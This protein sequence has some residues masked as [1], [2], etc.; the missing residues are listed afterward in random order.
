MVDKE[1]LKGQIERQ[2]PMSPEEL[3]R[4]FNEDEVELIYR[5]LT[6]SAEDRNPQRQVSDEHRC[7][8]F[9][10]DRCVVDGFNCSA[11]PTS[12]EHKICRECFSINVAS[13]NASDD[14]ARQMYVSQGIKL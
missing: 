14:I 1:K 5:T 2:E 12:A 4:F 7:S 6:V 13:E 8:I 11:H 10:A 3:R 9:V